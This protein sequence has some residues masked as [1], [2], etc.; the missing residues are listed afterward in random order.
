M[1]DRPPSLPAFLRSRARALGPKP[2]LVVSSSGRDLVWTFSDLWAE[3][4]RQASALLNQ[5]LAPRSPV[6]LVGP[7]SPQTLLAE[8]ALQALQCFAIR[9]SPD[10]PLDRLADGARAAEVPLLMHHRVDPDRLEALQRELSDLWFCPVPEPVPP[11]GPARAEAEDSH[12]EG[13]ATS[14]PDAAGVA[15]LPMGSA[16]LVLARVLTQR[17]LVW[18]GERVGREVGGTEQDLWW[19]PMPGYGAAPYTAGLAPAWLSGGVVGLA[20]ESPG[21]ME[22]LW[23]LHPTV[24]VLRVPEAERLA[25]RLE[26]EVSRAAGWNGRLAR[27]ALHSGRDDGR[28][29]AARTLEALAGRS[30]RSVLQSLVGGRLDRLVVLG[31]PSSRALA[32]FNAF[33][34]TC[35]AARGPLVAAE[36][37]TF[38]RLPLPEPGGT[39]VPGTEVRRDAEGR[40]EVRGLSATR[41]L[42]LRNWRSPERTEDW[43]PTYCPGTLSGTRVRW[44]PSASLPA[45]HIE[46][47]L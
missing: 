32:C 45:T 1:T 6:L 38:D 28:S 41:R 5:G 44:E 42:P 13:L 29:L 43:L 20:P 25:S 2:A 33:Q 21:P 15:V 39:L 8:L 19:I 22:G 34:V 16:D 35:F 27:W 3:I 23:R 24:A 37:W 47:T 11:E 30:A 26:E 9:M 12:L 4:R 17:N 40:L 10:L 18:L 46:E 7:P 31:E 14:G 36:L